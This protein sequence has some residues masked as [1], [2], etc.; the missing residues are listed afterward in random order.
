[1]RLQVSPRVRRTAHSPTLEIHERVAAL[2]RAGQP[3]VH[4]GFGQ[5][6][7]PAPP[8]VVDALTEHAGDNRYTPSQGLPDLREVAADYLCW[9]FKHHASPER[10]C[11]GPGSK[12]LIF[13]ALLALAGDLILPAPSWV[14]YAPQA[15]LLGKKVI[16]A[17]T[18]PAAG[19]RM[20]AQDLQDACKRSKS[21]Q[22]LL[23]LNSP[24]NPTGAV[25]SPG[26]L[27]DIA[28]VAR[29]HDVVVISDEI[30]AEITFA[31]GRYTSIA[32]FCPERTL[33]TTGLSKGFCAGGYRLGIVSLP[34]EMGEIVPRLVNVASETF[35]CV[36]APIQ[37]AAAVAFSRNR[38]VRSHVKDTVA[39]HKAAGEYLCRELTKIGLR[40]PEPEGAFYLFPDFS[41]FAHVLRRKGIRT[42]AKLCTDMLEKQRLAMLPG[43][44]FGVPPG[45]L[46]VRLATVDY[47]GEAVLK[48][49]RTRRPRSKTEARAFVQTRCPNLVIG[50]RKI[51][52]YLAAGL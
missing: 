48:A 23:V 30:Y 46:A 35:S 27:Q 1:M 12:A 11:V 32:A 34:A 51:K 6:P 18:D 21:R 52:E 22:K 39:I 42:D 44:A 7:F 19:Y 14:S 40:C 45:H 20:T 17:Q 8:P 41:R 38:E 26:E 16:W 5:S 43:A 33:V 3:L 15:K 28:A 9:R 37:H 31:R 10:I 29:R 13:D 49:F 4:F 2:R 25:Y 36:S 24:C 50:V 47:N